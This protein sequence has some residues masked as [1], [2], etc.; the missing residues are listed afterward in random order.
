MALVCSN[1]GMTPTMVCS[2]I[3]MALTSV[4]LLHG[5]AQ[6]WALAIS[7]KLHNGMHNTQFLMQSSIIPLFHGSNLNV[8]KVVGFLK[9]ANQN[10]NIDDPISNAIF[11]N[12]TSNPHVYRVVGL[13]RLHGEIGT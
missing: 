8:Y 4:L 1:I 10:R 7:V 12:S 11:H 5:Y 9:I 6:T 13:L 2:D 3:G